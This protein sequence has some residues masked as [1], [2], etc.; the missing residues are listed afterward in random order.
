MRATNPLPLDRSPLL[1]GMIHLPA[2]PGAPAHDAPMDA[3]LERVDRDARALS[4]AGFDAL[5]V[6]NYG[7]TPFHPERVPPETVAALTRAVSAAIAAAPNHP[8]GVN[9]LR[10]DA[11]SALGIAAATGASFMRVNVHTGSMY[12]D[13]GLLTGRAWQTLRLRRALNLDCA[14]LADVMVKHA[15]PPAGTTLDDAA[16]DLRERGRADAVIVS[17]A[18]TGRPTDPT[19]ISRLRA[20]LPDAPLLV[21]S[22][23]TPDSARALLE[24]GATGLIVGSW[25]QRGGRAGAGVDPD[26]ASRFVEA[27]RSVPPAVGID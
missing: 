14:I 21:G 12:T 25:V 7:D 6:E 27:V 9:V 13:Q 4:A 20:L 1:I 19:R 23:A 11:R 2:L 15:A 26:R 22:G 18:G 24:A 5:L 3:I 17:G 10:N 8:V 16:L